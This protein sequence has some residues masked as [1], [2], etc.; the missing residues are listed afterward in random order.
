MSGNQYR[1]TLHAGD[2]KIG[3]KL[4]ARIGDYGGLIDALREVALDKPLII[5]L[6]K[7]LAQKSKE[8]S[9]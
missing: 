9:R 5:N 8:S 4:K 2:E 6:A 1:L 7:A 3:L